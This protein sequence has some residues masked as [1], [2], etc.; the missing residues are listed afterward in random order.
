MLFVFLI[1]VYIQEHVLIIQQ[2]FLY[3]VAVVFFDFIAY[4]WLT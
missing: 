3:N 4:R 2:I 1:D